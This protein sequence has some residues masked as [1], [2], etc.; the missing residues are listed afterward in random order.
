MKLGDPVGEGDLLGTVSDPIGR[1]N[2][3]A[4]AR[5]EGIV[6]AL[7]VFPRVD[8]GDCLGVILEQPTTQ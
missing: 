7:R 6:I 4:F 8:R 2:H 1:T 3:P 5:Q